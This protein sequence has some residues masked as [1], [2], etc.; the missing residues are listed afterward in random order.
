VRLDVLNRLN[1][2][3]QVRGRPVRPARAAA[4][5]LLAAL[6]LLAISH[7]VPAQ[8][9]AS[10]AAPVV[11]AHHAAGTTPAHAHHT[12]ARA[13]RE[14]TRPSRVMVTSGNSWATA[15]Y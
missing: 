3:P 1:V 15:A 2:P 14:R 5:G 4:T 13:S 9:A 12:S 7:V 8:A 11:P 10:P 6:A